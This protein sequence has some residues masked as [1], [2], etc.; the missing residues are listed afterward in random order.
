MTIEFCPFTHSFRVDG[1][2]VPSVTQILRDL[3][4]SDAQWATEY[5]RER[6]TAVHKAAE[7]IFS[8]GALD[9][10]SIDPAIA[11][12][13]GAIMA[14]REHYQTRMS[15]V[16]ACEQ[17]VATPRWAGIADLIL[18]PGVL[19]IKTGQEATWHK[20]QIAA[21]EKAA[22]A[23]R[24]KATFH[25][26]LIY[27]RESGRYAIRSFDAYEMY[28]HAEQFEV[29]V[30]VWCLRHNDNPWPSTLGWADANY[31]RVEP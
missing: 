15:R 22:L 27:M 8:G 11:G 24:G 2:Q 13:V 10:E 6:G 3:Q 9:P 23:V 21:Y 1:R 18:D 5:S 26:S 17:I 16:I 20:Y 4:F 12:H 29:I 28:R 14:Y 30:S 7:I 25:G 31:E 19:D